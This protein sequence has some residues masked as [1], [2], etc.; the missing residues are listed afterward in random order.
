MANLNTVL[1]VEDDK[2]TRQMLRDSLEEENFFVLEAAKGQRSIEILKEHK[3]NI[4]LLDLYL[5]DS[6][7]LEY[8]PLIRALTNVPILVVSG[9]SDEQKQ[10]GSLEEGAD[11]FIPKPIDFKMLIAKVKV[12]LRRFENPVS[13]TVSSQLQT[14]KKPEMRFGKWIIDAQKF[15]IFDENENSANLTIRE[16]QILSLLINNAGQTLKRDELCDAIR[17]KNY[18]PSARTIDV[19]ITRI[20]KKIGDDVSHPEIIETVRGV[21]YLFKGE[22]IR[23]P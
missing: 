7:G 9:E 11:D 16:F 8:I 1:L 21:G 13:E 17:E 22:I 2:L 5:P 6:H 3:V 18:V 4:V 10:I 12:H 15:Q 23:T 14:F 20:R 19:K